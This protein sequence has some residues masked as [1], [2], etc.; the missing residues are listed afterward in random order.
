MTADWSKVEL[1]AVIAIEN[2]VAGTQNFCVPF[3]PDSI[4][5]L[6]L[7]LLQ[8][9]AGRTLREL[10]DQVGLSP[11][12]IQRRIR[13]YRA[14]GVIAREVAVLDARELGPT[15]LTVVLVTLE[16][17]SVEHHT[18]FRERMLAEPRVQQCY[19]LAGQWDY[20][21]VLVAGS[22]VECRALS[23]RLFMD[24]EN[25][26]RYDTLPVLDAVKTGSVVPLPES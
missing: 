3:V 2:P 1:G 14:S 7:R 17:E 4:D 11:S 9:D 23:D 6:L 26:R 5:H 15:T 25:V 19:D 16:R 10:G 22:L 13:G 18:A 24:D 8:E 20:V 12:A 21:V